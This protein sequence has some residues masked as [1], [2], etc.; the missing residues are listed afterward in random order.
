MSHNNPGCIAGQPLTRSRRNARVAF[1]H[2]LARRTSV[3]EYCLIDVNDDLIAFARRARL[4]STMERGLRDK[5][6]R[7]GLLLLHDWRL[8]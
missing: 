6:Q 4:H 8:R 2:R 1:E 7:V 5:R 3:G